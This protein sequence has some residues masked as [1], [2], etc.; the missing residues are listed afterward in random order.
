MNKKQKPSQPKNVE[1]E[2]ASVQAIP[3]G[4]WLKKPEYDWFVNGFNYA[5]TQNAVIP[6]L[7]KL[8]HAEIY[9]LLGA[10]IKGS[11]L[12]LLKNIETIELP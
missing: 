12:K 11:R 2:I 10:I 1:V 9:Y 6:A 5:C 7:A 3:N 4:H 8:E